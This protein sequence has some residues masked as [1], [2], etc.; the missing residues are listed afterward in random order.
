[1]KL[2]LSRFETTER[3]TLRMYD[4]TATNKMQT[5]VRTHYS[6]QHRSSHSSSSLCPL[7]LGDCCTTGTPCLVSSVPW[8]LLH[9]KWLSFSHARMTVLD[10]LR[11]LSGFLDESDPDV[12]F[13]LQSG[14][15]G[16]RGQSHTRLPDGRETA[17]P[18]P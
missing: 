15:A 1:M 4:E 9:Q 7:L 10:C 17:R 13:A 5:C 12:D 16:Q 14:L 3:K 6:K 11:T 2:E 8:R 18:V